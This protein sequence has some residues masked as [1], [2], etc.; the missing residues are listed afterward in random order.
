MLFGLIYRDW[1]VSVGNHSKTLTQILDESDIKLLDAI[2]SAI[3]R[4]NA[5]AVSRAQV[6]LWLLTKS[7]T[8]TV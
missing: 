4:V 7:L 5:K 6:L 3:S 1:C 2:Q 8:I